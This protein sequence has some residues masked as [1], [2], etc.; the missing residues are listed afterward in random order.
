MEVAPVDPTPGRLVAEERL[1]PR[2]GPKQR[3]GTSLMASQ[4]FWPGPAGCGRHQQQREP[5]AA[6][7]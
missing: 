2:Q 3:V 7:S 1:R 4:W 6:S 5:T